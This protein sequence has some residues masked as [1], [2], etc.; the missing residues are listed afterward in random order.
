MKK[1]KERMITYEVWNQF[2]VWE[3]EEESWV[4]N[5][6]CREA[7]VKMP[8]TAT[9]MD[10]LKK[11]KELKL[12]EKWVSTRHVIIEDWGDLVEVYQRKDRMPLFYF[13]EKK[14]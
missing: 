8:I 11:L 5:N 12:L 13:I 10:F 7:T 1:E 14:R 3:S 6:Q 4:V 2:D 9:R